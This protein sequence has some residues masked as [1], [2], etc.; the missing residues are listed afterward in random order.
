MGSIYI[1]GTGY[2]HP[3][4][5]ITNADLEALVDTS[6]HWILEHTGIVERRRAAPHQSTSDL[7][8]VA[9]RRALEDAGWAAEELDL[10]ICGTSSPDTTIPPTACHL[11]H[12]LGIHAVAFDVNGACAS[13]AYALAAAKSFM[14]E[15]GHRKVA[16]CCA[17]RYTGLTDYRDR[18]TCV[19][20]GDG[21]A[22]LLL[23]T[24][25]PPRGAEIVDILLV[26]DHEW[27][28]L[29]SVPV[30]GYFEFAGSQLKEPA[31][32]L[33]ASNASA[34]LERHGLK[35][36]DIRAFMGHQANYRLLQS[37][38]KRLGV[39]EEQHW[40]NVRMMGNQGAAGAVTTFCEGVERHAADL[41][42]G[43]LFLLTVVGSGLTS[44][45]VL[46]RWTESS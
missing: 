13:F 24:E 9:T 36:S 28:D 42:D 2:Y 41:R 19:L 22:T 16:L 1:R 38:G 8:L 7:G 40:S 35:M 44:G 26:N 37:V 30:G 12:K 46:L 27:I 15:M 4:E 3:E 33:L 43:D 39:V 10:L 17:E 34:M 45:C 31:G 21:A 6:D 11:A 23:D 29:V 20:F 18:R 14:K 5:R 25:Q 32:Q